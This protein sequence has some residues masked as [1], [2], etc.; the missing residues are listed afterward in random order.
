MYVDPI[1]PPLIGPQ[2]KLTDDEEI[3]GW[4]FCARD[5]INSYLN[6]YPGSGNNSQF[7]CPSAGCVVRG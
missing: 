7:V 4:Y 1:A 3:G 2:Q 5:E 6:N